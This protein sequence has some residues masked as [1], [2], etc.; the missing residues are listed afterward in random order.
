MWKVWENSIK[1]GFEE[2]KCKLV[3]CKGQHGAKLLRSLVLD[4]VNRVKFYCKKNC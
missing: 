3:K 1:V 4:V 2:M